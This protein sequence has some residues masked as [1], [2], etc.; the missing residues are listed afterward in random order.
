VAEETEDPGPGAAGKSSG[1]HPAAMSLAFGAAAQ[2]ER[3]AALAEAFLEEQ[4]RLAKLQ[5]E[6]LQFENEKLEEQDKF[7]V[8]RLRWRRFNDQMKG[9]IQIVVLALGALAV[10][11]VVAIVWSA[12]NDHAL[13]V[14]SF[15]VPSDLA[16]QGETGA[17][18]A[19][20]VMD[21]VATMENQTTSFRAKSSY[22]NDWSNDIKVQ[23]PDTGISVGDAYRLLVG[24][25]GN[26]THISGE[27]VHA[28]IG[29]AVTVRVGSG[30]SATLE[31]PDLAQLVD[32]S[33]EHI[34]DSTQ[35]YLYSV[36]LSAMGRPDEGRR[37]MLE[38]AESNGPASERAWA[39]GGLANQEPDY[40]L[41]K[42]YGEDAIR[43]KPDLVIA[44]G[45]L[46]TRDRGVGHDEAALKERETELALLSGRAGENVSREQ[47]PF[48]RLAATAD[49]ALY[50]GD[51]AGAAAFD[52]Q[53]LDVAGLTY[54]RS[55]V[56]SSL[57]FFL[58]E[59]HDLRAFRAVARQ[60]E[61]FNVQGYGAGTYQF[62]L[63]NRVLAK[64]DA[65]SQLDDWNMV[66][67]T[68]DQL[69]KLLAGRAFPMMLPN[70]ELA[71]A[72]ARLGDSFKA[73]AL[74]ATTPPD[75]Y[76]CVRMRGK[77]RAA[78]HNWDSAAYWFAEAAKQGPSL[79][80]ADTDWGEMLL[81]RGDYDAAIAKFADASKKGPHFADPLEMWGEA[82]MLKNRS[83]LALARFGEADKYAP[84]WGRMHLKWGEALYWSGDK[85]GA[86]KQFDI[87]TGLDL[88]AA[89]KAEL[90]RVSAARG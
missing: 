38:L 79:P 3:V 73:H 80:F 65:A 64:C 87:A 83:D 70:A 33:A 7:E 69:P 9:A 50:R 84:N 30:S 15:S 11:G 19:A 75:C 14:D 71:Y 34:M 44:W 60:D 57:A 25:I 46:P 24:W 20:H 76:L 31:G 23:I 82:L 54:R 63:L 18:I 4:T 1:V 58:A 48:V 42:A 2:S 6:N 41:A 49:F 56:L 27:I 78:E 88:S 29:Y 74:I 85:A 12:A 68:V 77:I 55:Q 5:I 59:D 39:Y 26:E 43:L 40:S 32:K 22:Q 37:R 45:N 62:I 16:A 51:Y 21:A 8:S 66:V 90:S 10:I 52:R 89:D 17:V 13:V 72:Y 67:R 36:W 35:P 47:L 53:A 81:H 61:I 86:Q 28:K